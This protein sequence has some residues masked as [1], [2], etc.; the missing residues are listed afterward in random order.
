MEHKEYFLKTSVWRLF[1]MAALPGAISM[2]ASALYGLFDGIFVGQILGDTAFAAINLAFPFVIINFAIS[3]LI[4]VGSAVPISIALGKQEEKEANNIFTCA[5]LMIVGAGVFMGILMYVGSPYLLAFLDASEEAQR[6]AVQYI[7]VYAIFSPLITGGFALDN[8]LRIS[9]KTKF[10]M[11]LSIAV[12]IATALLEFVFLFV[13]KLDIWGAALASCLSMLAFVLIAFLPFALGK[14]TLHLTRPKFSKKTTIQIIKCGTPIFLANIS[15]RVT[16][17]VMN[18]ALISMGG[19]SAVAIYGMQM[20]LG[21]VLNPVIYGLCDSTQ[22]AIGYN[23]GA[24]RFD[25]VKKLAKC[26]FSASAI[27][28]IVA[29]LA[30]FFLPDVLISLFTTSTDVA[31]LKEATKALKIFAVSKLFFWFAFSTQCYMTA[32][33]KSFYATLISVGS[34]FIFPILFIFA[35]NSIGLTGLWLNAPLTMGACTIM[36]LI[37]LIVFAK[38]MKKKEQK[39]QLK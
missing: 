38:E 18:K 33:E 19:D 5:L 13:L 23:W 10:G 1:F 32:V 3:D 15:G 36:S 6:L 28:S 39:I 22:P 37:I 20:Y 25:R 30:M 27:V 31:F 17:V 21:E 34:A 26:I 24:K 4:A 8:Y 12:S 9:G 14:F 7:R 35:L 11:W 29:F 2:L 16:S